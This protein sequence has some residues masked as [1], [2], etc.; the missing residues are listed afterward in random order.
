MGLNDAGQ[1]HPGEEEFAD[2][3]ILN[4]IDFKLSNEDYVKA[5]IDRARD[6]FNKESGNNDAKRKYLS[7]NRI[8]TIE[9]PLILRKTLLTQGLNEEQKSEIMVSGNVKALIPLSRELL[10]PEPLPNNQ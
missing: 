8:T 10:L 1:V 3:G 5:C 6:F 7:D 9:T 2:E 4:P